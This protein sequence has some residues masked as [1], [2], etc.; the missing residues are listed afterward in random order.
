[1]EEI[2]KEEEKG[3]AEST[4]NKKQLVDNEIINS[5]KIIENMIKHKREIF[6]EKIRLFPP[7]IKLRQKKNNE[8]LKINCSSEFLKEIEKDHQRKKNEIIEKLK[9]YEANI[10]KVDKKLEK[11]KIKINE[12]FEFMETEDYLKLKK[13]LIMFEKNIDNFLKDFNQ[14]FAGDIKYIPLDK[15]SNFHLTLEEFD[16]KNEKL[17]NLGKSIEEVFS[18]ISKLI[19]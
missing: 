19:Q 8:L 15:F 16:I 9:L 11:L 4:L 2:E 13:N 6:K 5:I 14:L 17:F 10:T 7:E 3:T 12:N 18:F 1:M